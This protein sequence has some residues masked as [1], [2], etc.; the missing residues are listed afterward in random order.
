MRTL[1]ALVWT[2]LLPAG[3]S[4]AASVLPPPSALL[5]EADSL[6]SL[7]LLLSP[8]A[9]G[10][11][12]GAVYGPAAEAGIRPSD[13]L[14]S[15]NGVRTASALDAARALSSWTPASRLS[16]V[17][18]RGM[19][20]QALGTPFLP[21]PPPSARDHRAL[22]PHEKRLQGLQQEEA[23][24][25]SADALRPRVPS[26]F[27]IAAGERL[28]MR[29]PAGIPAEL[30]AG[31][32]LEGVTSTAMATDADL[33]FLAVPEGTALWA[34]VVSVQDSGEVRLV[35][36]HVYKLRLPSGGTYP[37]SAIVVD[38]SG[39]PSV[40]KVSP[41]GTLVAAH[42]DASPQLTDPKRGFQLWF[43]EPTTL[44]E[45]ASA[46]LA[47]PG[48]WLKT[49]GSG[50]TR[51][52]EVT[53]A[54][55]GRSA[56][57]AGIRAGDRILE[58]GGTPSA[59]LSFP[60]AIRKLYGRPGTEVEVRVA[61][62]DGP[63]DAR[64]VRGVRYR[65]G[66]GMLCARSGDG[67]VVTEVAEDSPARRAGI[68]PGDTLLAVGS[69]PTRDMDGRRVEELLRAE[70]GST[71]LTVRSQDKA[72]RTVVVGAGWYSSPIPVEESLSRQ[73]SDKR[74]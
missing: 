21:P 41:G 3:P 73:K 40:L 65:K 11:K 16:A 74:Y 10:P 69:T 64:L 58:V 6:T 53:H 32:V 31:Q 62:A 28:W 55:A 61:G 36:L 67:F 52:F 51:A 22:T 37:C 50:E 8:A 63:R 66:S 25:A 54:I 17:V 68:A 72:P 23:S 9:P 70:E 38:V 44:H 7:G 18:L 60:E 12:V 57:H 15:L 24:G 34:K 5:Q 19:R 13:T 2:L 56:A 4:A 14:L 35:R 42:P 33:D 30:S 45:P 43:L 20:V 26:S 48:L 46:Y 39:D 49:T 29:L 1:R 59:K 71:G 27:R 47:G